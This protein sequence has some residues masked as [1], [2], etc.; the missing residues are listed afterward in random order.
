[1]GLWKS[2]GSPPPI[3]TKKGWLLLYHGVKE[4]KVKSSFIK[5]ILKS[6]N[7][8]YKYYVGAA[9]FDLKDPKKLIA[10]SK[11]TIM[12]PNKKYE[13][14]TFEKN[15][16]IVFPTGIVMDKNNKD[17]LIFS[18]GG[19]RIVTVRKIAL[20]DILNKLKKV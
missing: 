12:A 5:R 9:L 1:M 10:K 3:K 15:K 17:L 6:S 13:K 14:G 20:S 19:D 7:F 4:E 11:S 18:G 16:E 2:R 8:I